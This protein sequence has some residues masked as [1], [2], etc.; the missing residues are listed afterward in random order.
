MILNNLHISRNLFPFYRIISSAIKI[1]SQNVRNCSDTVVMNLHVIGNRFVNF[2]VKT[3]SHSILI[4]P[5][6]FRMFAIGEFIYVVNNRKHIRKSETGAFN[7]Q[8]QGI[9]TN[10]VKKSHRVGVHQLGILGSRINC[11]RFL[12]IYW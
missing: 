7:R 5:T 4:I 6:G 9:F 3:V 12:K 1:S 11:L 10:R 2:W 8:M